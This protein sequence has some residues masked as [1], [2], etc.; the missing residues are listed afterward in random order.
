VINADSVQVY[1]RLD[2]GSA[3]LSVDEREGVPHHL[4]DLL[5]PD[6]P[7]DAAAFAAD[8]DRAIAE[9]QAR[10][11]LPIVC[12]GTGMYLR[13]L[14]YGIFD[15][16]PSDPGLRAQLQARAAAEGSQALHAEL[17]L[18]DPTSAARLPH[19]DLVRVIRALE[20]HALTG[21]ALSSFHD[22]H[23]VKARPPRYDCLQVALAPARETL[24]ARI[25]ARV[26]A[27]MAQGF[28]R[29]VQDLLRDGYGPELKPL[30]SLGY[31]HLIQHLR[32]E[33]PSLSQTVAELKR[34]HRH[35]AK[36]Q[37][38][39]L[40]AQPH[41]LWFDDPAPALEALLRAFAAPQT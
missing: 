32:G 38:T 17:V 29:E 28:L 21:R 30:Q 40:R 10:G 23:Q 33:Q 41:L 11:K 12:G 1:Q 9:V 20:V 14:L 35:Y 24:Y 15:A 25:D 34:D 5:A 31:R 37:L 3:K 13:A 16:P 19:Q 6:A 2:I 4:L 27:M 8:A 7:Y 18:V 39:W 22:E 26:D 36:R